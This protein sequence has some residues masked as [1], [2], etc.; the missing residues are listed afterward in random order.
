M[1]KTFSGGILVF[2]VVLGA[3]SAQATTLVPPE[4]RALEM[5]PRDVCTSAAWPRIPA[6]CLTG[7]S[8]H[9]VRYAGVDSQ[10]ESEVVDRFRV[11]FE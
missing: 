10:I 1:T 8:G 3:F 2:A 7:G 11:A 6:K 9:E 4:G 5:Q